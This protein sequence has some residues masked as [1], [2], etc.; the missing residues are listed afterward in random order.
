LFRI[1]N[2]CRPGTR[3]GDRDDRDTQGAAEYRG[4]AAALC[5]AVVDAGERGVG[6]GLCRHRGVK[7]GTEIVIVHVSENPPGAQ[8]FT[9]KA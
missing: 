2:K 3:C 1:R 6:S 8:V 4:A 9:L 5:G 7:H